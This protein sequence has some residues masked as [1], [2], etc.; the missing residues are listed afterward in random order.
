M[1][2]KG[3]LGDLKRCGAFWRILNR[4]ARRPKRRFIA[5]LLMIF[6]RKKKLHQRPDILIVEG[7]NVLQPAVLAKEGTEIPFVSD[8]FDFSIYIDAE[9][10]IAALV[11]RAFYG[12]APNRV[13]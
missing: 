1:E 10:E 3:F 4:G 7:L 2:R 13:S 11:C 5:I 9:A 8:Y 6:C 12:A